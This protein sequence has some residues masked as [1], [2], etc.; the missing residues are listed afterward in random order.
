MIVTTDLPLLQRRFRIYRYTVM[1]IRISSVVRRHRMVA[2]LECT[3]K[4]ADKDRISASE[5]KELRQIFSVSW[6]E[7]KTNE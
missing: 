4:K 3:L 5:M 2:N 6:A 1:S 7:R